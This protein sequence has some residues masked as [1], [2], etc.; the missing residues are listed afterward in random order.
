MPIIPF[1]MLTTGSLISS[2]IQIFPKFC[3]LIVKIYIMVELITISV[4]TLNHERASNIRTELLYEVPNIHSF[5]STDVYNTPV[6][7]LLH[8]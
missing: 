4:I 7:N 6:F 2:V 8:R 3:A 5:Y 1:V